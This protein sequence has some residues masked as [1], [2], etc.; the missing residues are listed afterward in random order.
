[1]RETAPAT[2]LAQAQSL[3]AREYSFPSWADL[4]AEVGRRAC[5]RGQSASLRKADLTPLHAQRFQAPPDED[6]GIQTPM[7]FFRLGVIVQ[8][9]LVFAALTGLALVFVAIGQPHRGVVA[10]ALRL[11][12]PLA[13]LIRAIL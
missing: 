6:A 5:R 13:D 4:Q 3:V 1:M 2:R 8:V 9:G 7:D 11:G 12:R 10:M